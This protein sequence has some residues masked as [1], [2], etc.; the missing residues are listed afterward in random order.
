VEQEERLKKLE[1]ETAW[2]RMELEKNQKA[3]KLLE[4]QFKVSCNSMSA[5]MKPIKEWTDTLKQAV[6]IMESKRSQ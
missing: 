5:V 6:K 4:D 1:E 3:Q 2:L